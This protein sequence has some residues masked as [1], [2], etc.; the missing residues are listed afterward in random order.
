MLYRKLINP[1][2]RINQQKETWSAGAGEGAVWDR[3]I[4]CD[5]AESCLLGA[6]PLSGEQKLAKQPLFTEKPSLDLGLGN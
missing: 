4:G 3:G 6:L 1:I 2:E 5:S